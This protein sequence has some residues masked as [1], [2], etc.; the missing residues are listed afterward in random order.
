LVHAVSFRNDY[1]SGTGIG[2][3][4]FA[5][6]EFGAVGGLAESAETAKKKY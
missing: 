2:N 3:A 6:T 4:E 5:F 1:S